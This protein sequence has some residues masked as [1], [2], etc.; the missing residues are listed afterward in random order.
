MQSFERAENPARQNILNASKSDPNRDRLIFGI[1]AV[2]AALRNN[3]SELYEVRVHHDRQDV[4]LNGLRAL[5][6]ARNVRLRE[7]KAR[8]LDQQAQGNR[9]QGAI[10][11]RRPSRAAK[12]SRLS[13]VLDKSAYPLMLVLD[14]VTDPHNLGA[15]LRTAEAA[16][17]DAV[18][19]PKNRAAGINA[20][21]RKVACGAAERVPLLQVTNLARELRELK[22][23]GLWLIGTDSAAPHSFY[24]LDLQRPLALLMGSEDKG[25]RRLT[26]ESCDFV[27]RVPMGGEAESLNVSVAA[28]V[29]LFEARR[30]RRAHHSA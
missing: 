22:D 2:L 27:A 6:A 4:R 8:I 28:G 24:D 13:M 26:R 3:P 10:A 15:I 12:E 19:V 1:H 11:S 14:G 7:V 23:A 5:A 20:T 9:H 30:Q 17:V 25:L 29:C 21:V 18:I 16:G